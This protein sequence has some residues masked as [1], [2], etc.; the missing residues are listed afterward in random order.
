MA[1][2]H[3]DVEHRDR[4][5]LAAAGVEVM[6]TAGGTEWKLGPNFDLA[7]ILEEDA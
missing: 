1:V 4:Q 7:K 2:D 5:L 3:L 6:D